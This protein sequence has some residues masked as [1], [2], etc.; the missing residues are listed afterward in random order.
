LRALARRFWN[1]ERRCEG[2][3][4]SWQSVSDEYQICTLRGVMLSWVASWL[5]I[6]RLGCCS[7]LKV[8]S[9]TC[10][11]SGDVRFLFRLPERVRPLSPSSRSSVPMLSAESS[12][13]GDPRRKGSNG[14]TVGMAG[15]CP[16]GA[17][18]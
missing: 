15:G 14:T 3:V 17:E 18:L 16:A 12:L 7:M 8:V 13:L 2:A 10:N 9:S 4:Q 5:R 11:C 1:L 6:P